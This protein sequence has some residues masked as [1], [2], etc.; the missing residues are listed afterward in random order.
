MRLSPET[1]RYSITVPF[2]A[3]KPLTFLCEKLAGRFVPDWLSDFFTWAFLLALAVLLGFLFADLTNP[4]TGISDWIRRKRAIFDAKFNPASE[5]RDGS[6]VNL[7][8]FE[9]HF[10]K[11]AKRLTVELVVY[12]N[13]Q[14]SIR[15]P[16]RLLSKEA[17]RDYS[18]GETI[19]VHIATIPRAGGPATWIDGRPMIRCTGNTVQVRAVKARRF[20][21]VLQRYS[22]FLSYGEA[23]AATGSSYYY[24]QEERQ[25]FAHL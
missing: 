11:R 19:K 14:F 20:F 24:L 15:R 13:V 4:G 8:N 22:V 1:L 2:V 25:V 3:A 12:E 9:L 18:E 16:P 10:R 5:V 21:P 23:D 7:P 17:P 6:D